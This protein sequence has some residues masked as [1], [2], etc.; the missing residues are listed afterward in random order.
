M[1][2]PLSSYGTQQ[3]TASMSL[4]FLLCKMGMPTSGGVTV[5]TEE[6]C[7]L[8]HP[9]QDCMLRGALDVGVP[10]VPDNHPARIRPMATITPVSADR[11]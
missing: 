4:S 7:L 8:S 11:C 1:L 2:S 9:A 3:G 5:R 6:L 10:I